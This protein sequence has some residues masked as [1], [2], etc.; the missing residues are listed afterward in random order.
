MRLRMQSIAGRATGYDVSAYLVTGILVDTGFHRA[1]DEMKRALEELNVRGAI[2]THWHEDHAGNVELIAS[3]GTPLLLRDDTAGILRQRPPVRLYRRA[4]WGHPPP[5]RSQVIPL[6][7][8]SLEVIHPPGHSHDH[9]G[10]WAAQADTVFGGDLCLGV[11][12]R[13]MHESENPYEIIESL[14]RVLERRPGRL[15]D[16]HR[17]QI[18][19]PVTALQA[20]IDWMS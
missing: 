9:Q 14:R 17:G 7:S 10:G 1:R 13:V 4:V 11:R 20:K 6:D 15:F 2:V 16:A 3:R 8:G 5:L 19:S 12:P 18:A